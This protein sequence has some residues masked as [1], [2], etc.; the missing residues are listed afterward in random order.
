MAGRCTGRENLASMRPQPP[1]AVGEFREESVEVRLERVR[2]G[3]LVQLLFALD[4][5]EAYLKV[6]ELRIKSRFDD[7]SLLDAVLTVASYRRNP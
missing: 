7:R 6:K 2:L 1:A 5:A 4:S 3:Q